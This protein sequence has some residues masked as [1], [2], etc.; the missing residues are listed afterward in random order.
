MGNP[1]GTC[2]RAEMF[3]TVAEAFVRR[4]FVDDR[5]AAAEPTRMVLF[6]STGA[7]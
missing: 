4:W 3:L 6:Q 7:G 1:T 5:G 2:E